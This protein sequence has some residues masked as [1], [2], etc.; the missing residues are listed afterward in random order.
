MS[1]LFSDRHRLLKALLGLVLVL[2][3]GL[4]YAD[5]VRYRLSGWEQCIQDPAGHDGEEVV[6]STYMVTAIGSPSRY[7]IGGMVWGVQVEGASGGLSVG[8]RV[9]VRGRFRAAD[10]V[11]IEEEHHHHRLWHWKQGLGIL[12]LILAMLA[13]PLCFTVHGGRVVE[14]G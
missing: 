8:D 7:E 1:V 10:Q 6:F 5:T 12:G 9:S 13:A 11:V 3:M 4:W 14:R 2:T